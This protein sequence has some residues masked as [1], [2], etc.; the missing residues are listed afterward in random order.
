MSHLIFASC[1]VL[2]TLSS[3]KVDSSRHCNFAIF[4]CIAKF[5]KIS[6]NEV[7]TQQIQMGVRMDILEEDEQITVTV[8]GNLLTYQF[9]KV[10]FCC[11]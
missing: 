6:C 3:P 1:Y 9:F 8:F 2:D 5:A 10:H 7:L 4:F 11:F